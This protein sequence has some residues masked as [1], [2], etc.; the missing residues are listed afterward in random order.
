VSSRNFDFC[1]TMQRLS[2]D[3]RERA[4]FE[5]RMAHFCNRTD[6]ELIADIGSECRV[7]S[8]E[9]RNECLEDLARVRGIKE[10]DHEEMNSRIHKVS[11]ALNA[12]DPPDPPI[13][14]RRR[15]RGLLGPLILL[16][17]LRGIR[18]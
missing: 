1:S 7:V 18:R 11:N 15:R 16:F 3:Q 10:F 17:L 8:Q 6:S 13:I 2:S 14:R 9:E 5:R 12:S 4:Y